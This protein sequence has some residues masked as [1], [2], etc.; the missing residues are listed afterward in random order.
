MVEFVSWRNEDSS[1]FLFAKV[2]CSKLRVVCDV[3][4]PRRAIINAISSENFSA[5]ALIILCVK[6]LSPASIT[7]IINI[8]MLFNAT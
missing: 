1:I 6:S 2:P 7:L 4:H 5:A 8:Q 3:N